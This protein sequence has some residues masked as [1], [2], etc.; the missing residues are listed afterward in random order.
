MD[1]FRC[2]HWLRLV[3]TG[4]WCV[5]SV[6]ARWLAWA[7]IMIVIDRLCSSSVT[8]VSCGRYVPF[9]CIVSCVY[10]RTQL[11]KYILN[12]TIIHHYQAIRQCVCVVAWFPWCWSLRFKVVFKPDSCYLVHTLL[13]NEHLQV[14]L[15]NDAAR[16]WGVMGEGNKPLQIGRNLHLH[17]LGDL[18]HTPNDRKHHMIVSMV[19]VWLF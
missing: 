14:D 10:V 3:G 13:P 11:N 1:K 17:F 12:N 9:G 7:M 8:R 2:V 5:A 19:P 16:E 4:K 15:Q 18:E 6:I